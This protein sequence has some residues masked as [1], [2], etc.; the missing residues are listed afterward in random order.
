MVF[1][2]GRWL[3]PSAGRTPLGQGAS[4]G[5]GRT[6]LCT[7]GSGCTSY[8]GCT[9]DSNCGS[10]T[11][12]A[13]GAALGLGVGSWRG[14]C[15]GRSLGRSLGC[16]LGCCLGHGRCLGYGERWVAGLLRRRERRASEQLLA[17]E[18]E[19]RSNRLLFPA[20]NTL[21]SASGTFDSLA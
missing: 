21:R 13:L 1:T 12:A 15:L 2:L 17:Q 5:L 3:P 16:C 11:G 14:N 6:S 10:G 9:S 4:T 20:Q 19:R 7:S 18:A 8:S